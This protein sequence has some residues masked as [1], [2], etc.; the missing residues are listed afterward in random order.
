MTRSLLKE[1][2]TDITEVTVDESGYVL[3]V[4]HADGAVQEYA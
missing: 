1:T 2:G 4:D 3:S